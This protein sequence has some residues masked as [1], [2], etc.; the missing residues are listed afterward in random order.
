MTL[1]AAFWYLIVNFEHEWTM[2]D[3]TFIDVKYII[4]QASVIIKSS[5]SWKSKIMEIRKSSKM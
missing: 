1:M 2:C 4:I 5:L 3:L